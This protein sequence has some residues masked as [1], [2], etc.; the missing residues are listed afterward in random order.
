MSSGFPHSYGCQG[1][2]MSW[3]FLANQVSRLFQ[4]TAWSAIFI[5]CTI[6][7]R[8]AKTDL[9]WWEFTIWSL[10]FQNGGWWCNTSDVM[11]LGLYFFWVL[12][13]IPKTILGWKYIVLFI[14]LFCSPTKNA[15]DYILTGE[16][17]APPILDI[18]IICI[19]ILWTFVIFHILKEKKNDKTS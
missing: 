16:M 9:G 17:V 13:N 19:R 8:K 15:Q 11:I 4:I 1:H 18:M 2:V 7:K 5:K 10:M 14:C 12:Q 6:K 3:I